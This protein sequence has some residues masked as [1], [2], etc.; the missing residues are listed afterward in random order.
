[1]R[2]GATEIA[3]PLDTMARHPV[4]TRAY[5]KFSGHLLFTSSLPGR[6]RELL[7][8]R[9]A[10]ITDSAFEREQHEVIARKEG[11][12]DTEIAR[13]ADGPDAD[14]WSPA[15]AALLRATDELLSTWTVSD[16]TWQQLASTLDEHQ[17]MDLVF[18]V[19][20]YALF[21]MAL[22]SFGVEPDTDG[23]R[24]AEQWGRDRG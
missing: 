5:L 2:P 3:P 18:T 21:A 20:N 12:S 9:T 10:A 17:L 22:R 8:L 6:E 4:L 16:A 23:P 24:L 11:L 15:D 1:M 19:G 13:V 14:G 7:I